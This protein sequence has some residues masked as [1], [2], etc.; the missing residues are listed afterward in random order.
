MANVKWL[1]S[2]SVALKY[3]FPDFNRS[4]KDIDIL[5]PISVISHK[6]SE[7]LIDTDWHSAAQYILDR[8]ENS[9]FVDPNFLFTLKV[10]HAN[11]DIKWQKTMEDI[12]FMQKMGCALDDELYNL[13]IGVWNETH[14]KKQVNLNKPLD[15]FFSDYVQREMDHEQVHQ[16]VKFNDRAM[17]ELIRK[18]LNIALVSKEMF[19]SLEREQQLETIM[20]ETLV[21]AIERFGLKSSIV[22]SAKVRAFNAAYKQLVTSMTTG[23]FSKEMI[24]SYFE[25]FFNRREKW[26]KQI[27][28]I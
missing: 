20:E 5:S 6:P 22:K 7:L 12:A 2:G 17:H 10:S 16:L 9:T 4:P 27:P 24:L 14:G 13:L 23:W 28:K 3:W 11:W 26:L 1:I 25:I 15:E 8:N 18:D 19:Y 21:I